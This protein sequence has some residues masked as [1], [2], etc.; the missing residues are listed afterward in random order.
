MTAR[1]RPSRHDE[2]FA[3][4]VVDLR[5]ALAAAAERFDNSTVRPPLE[6]AGQVPLAVDPRVIAVIRRYFFACDRLN[7]DEEGGSQE[8]PHVFVV[9]RL[10]G[11]HDDVWKAVA[12]LPY[13][14][15]G[16]DELDNWIEEE[17]G[18]THPAHE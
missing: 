13:L 2:L 3:A 12:E 10:S 8:L 15:I 11:K 9:E 1:R 4:Y 17:L 6:R 14:P 5:A 7:R 16:T 18:S